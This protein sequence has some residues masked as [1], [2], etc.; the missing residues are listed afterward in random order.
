M[1][2][3][4]VFAAVLALAF[5]P[6]HA[7]AQTAASSACMTCHAELDEGARGTPTG[8]WANDVHRAAGLGCEDCHGG[9]AS[10]QVAEDFEASMSPGSGYRPP[11][12]RLEV[13]DFCG[14]CH[15]DA[16]Y[17]KQFD[18]QARVDQLVEYRTSVH[19]KRNAAG[20]PVPATC[21]DCHG[22]HGIRP[23]SSP[24]AA[25]YAVN[26]PATCAGCHADAERMAPYGLATDQ[27]D[28][29]MESMHALVLTELG[30]TAAPACNDCHGNHGAAPPGVQSVA[31]ICGQCHGREAALFRASFK[32]D[33]FEMLEVPECT[34]C[35]DHHRVLHP[36]PELFHAGSA[37]TTT[38][39]EIASLEPLVVEI[40]PLDAG[41]T[42]EI[43]WLTVLRPHFAADDK[44]LAHEVEI[45]VAGIPPLILDATH[46]PGE[47]PGSEP[48]RQEAGGLMATLSVE[49]M[50][51]TPL[52][53]GDA[54]RFRLELSA[55]GGAAGGLVVRDVSGAGVQP[56]AG[57]AC[58]TCHSP[59]DECDVA[60]EKMYGSLVGLEQELRGAAGV[61]HQAEVAGMEVGQP[62]FLLKSE[63]TT[64]AVEA[65]ALIHAFDPDRLLER[66]EE[67]RG[68]GA[69][70]LEAA[71]GALEELQF[72]RKGLG[73]SLILVALVAVGLFLKIRQLDA[74]P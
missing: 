70:V 37:P 57:S 40:G 23:V 72:R 26:V 1:M 15:G 74:S 8:G 62:R 58:L 10:P 46:R 3:G 38:H 61:L 29:Y 44:R 33:L 35:H 28:R 39:G 11:P 5:L 2:A 53:S 19:G 36:T 24:N 6:A 17:M 7:A 42:A 18:P 52:A 32:R 16:A 31:N 14:G 4:R 30:D 49:P 67:G 68:V 45:S 43:V 48:V 13:A 73:V 12:G 60:S 63:G 50:S 69:T 51:G 25:V 34:V 65:R 54:L 27:Y 21:T 56:V 20:D 41:E 47:S 9:D 64:A 59:G 55:A 66:T 71:R 22:T